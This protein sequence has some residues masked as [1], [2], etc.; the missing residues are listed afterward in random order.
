LLLLPFALL[1]LLSPRLLLMALPPVGLNLLASEKRELQWNPFDYHY[2]ASV[3]PWLLIATIYAVARLTESPKLAKFNLRWKLGRSL[4]ILVLALTLALNLGANL[5]VYDIAGVP[6]VKQGWGPILR[7][8]ESARWQEGKTLLKALPDD[9][10]V[11]I[12]NVWASY[13]KPRQGLWYLADRP[14]YSRHPFQQAQY[15]FADL[16][17]VEDAQ[18]VQQALATGQWRIMEERAEYAL[19]IKNVP[20]AWPSAGTVT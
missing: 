19:L 13:I 14:L 3:M 9:A 7:S 16:R 12:S 17:V 18:Q 11:A 20:A 2:Q 4:I 6:R 8:K 5:L 15:I 1:P 10:P